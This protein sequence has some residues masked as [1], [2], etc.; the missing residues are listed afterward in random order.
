MLPCKTEKATEVTKSLLREITPRFGLPWSIQSD[1]GLSFIVQ[2]IEQMA[3]DLKSNYYLRSAWH[4]QCSGKVE[5]A[6]H[7][8]KRHLT[9]VSISVRKLDY[10]F[11]GRTSQN[12]NR[13]SATS[14]GKP[15][16]ITIW[17]P[18]LTVDLSRDGDYAVLL[19]YSLE[20]G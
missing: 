18:V 1:H 4:P 6:N 2:I 17:I 20:A 19:N 11:T 9:K 12:E 13:P 7:T 14:R 15:L 10:S 8:L 16:G 3:R 5:K